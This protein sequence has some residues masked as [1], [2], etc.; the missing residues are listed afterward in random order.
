M[1]LYFYMELNYHYFIDFKNIKKCTNDLEIKY[2]KSK[3]KTL[4][5]MS[6]W[7]INFAHD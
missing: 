2:N 4:I 1:I 6:L 3:F 7:F 5:V